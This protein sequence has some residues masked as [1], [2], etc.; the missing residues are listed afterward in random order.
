MT[1]TKVNWLG[2]GM[3]LGFVWIFL[4]AAAY[5]LL[6]SLGLWQSLPPSLARGVDLLTGA[7]LAF[8]LLGH[9]A[10]TTGRLPEPP[11]PV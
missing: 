3:L 2:R 7:V 11:R 9:L 8:E 6:D 4:F 1:M 5:L 10:L